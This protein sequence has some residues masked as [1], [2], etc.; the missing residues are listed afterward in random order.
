MR[1]LHLNKKLDRIETH[2]RVFHTFIHPDLLPKLKSLHL[3]Q[4]T[5]IHNEHI[6]PCAFLRNKALELLI[7]GIPPEDV[8]QWIE[9]Y[10]QV[11]VISK[12][13]SDALDGPMK[14]RDKMPEGWLFGKGCT[15]ERLH[16]RNISLDL[17]EESTPCICSK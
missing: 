3:L 6:V 5:E 17:P 11:A 13:D 9:P 15:Y 1:Y 10:Y 16:L 2:S 8:A 7:H 12:E 14:L 4:G